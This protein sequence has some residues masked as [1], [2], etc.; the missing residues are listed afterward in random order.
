MT[1]AATQTGTRRIVVTLGAALGG[2]A[3]LATAVRLAGSL[4]AEIEGVFIEDIN[5]IQ[6][7]GLPFLRELS[8]WSLAE[9]AVSSQRMER[10]LRAMA[11]QARTLLEQE[12]IKLDVPWSFQVWRGHTGTE[13]LTG[14]F[15]T[16]ILSLGRL[17][18]LVSCRRWARAAHPP[19]VSTP[20]A[21]IGV[22]A[23]LSE[24]ATRAIT[25]AARLARD[26]GTSLTVF[27]P[28]G[29]TDRVLRLEE[30]LHVLL[31]TLDH[32]AARLM[33]LGGSDM[34]RLLQ[35][36]HAAGTGLLIA[37]AGHELLQTGGLERFQEALDRPVLLVR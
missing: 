15:N 6:L 36:A 28:E 7:A 21:G 4:G 37:E 10:Q 27:L 12:A 11:R 20:L 23:G 13:A 32:Q 34:Q 9:Q 26:L 33:P 3:P 29:G 30:R 35:A 22:L 25:T 2:R 8:P 17:S 1:A 18:A 24:P 16:D 19:P 14:A 31:G 5:L